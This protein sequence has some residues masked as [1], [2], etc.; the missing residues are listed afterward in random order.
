MAASKDAELGGKLAIKYSGWSQQGHGMRK[1][2]HMIYIEPKQFM[3]SNG[4][5]N[6][7]NFF[8]KVFLLMG[9]AAMKYFKTIVL[10]DFWSNSFIVFCSM[11]IL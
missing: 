2:I 9:M 8:P 10:M 11:L 7:G 5:Q 4:S 3:S 1:K 6:R